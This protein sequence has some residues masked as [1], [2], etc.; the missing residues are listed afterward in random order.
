M[1]WRYKRIWF[2]LWA[3]ALLLTAMTSD[4]AAQAGPST[5][6][7][8]STQSV[9]REE[10]LP[11]LQEL[12]AY[13]A[14]LLIT[15]VDGSELP[16]IYYPGSRTAQWAL[17]HEQ[18]KVRYMQTWARS[19]GVKLVEAEPFLKISWFRPRG[20]TVQL[21]IVQTLR[22]GYSYPDEEAQGIV[23]EFGIGTRHW[24]ELAKKDGVWLIRREWYTDPLGDDTLIY[25][26]TPAVGLAVPEGV[27]PTTPPPP[28][29]GDK[30][31]YDRLKAAAYADK[32]AGS[33]WGA[34][35]DGKYN[36][37]YRD[38]NGI[39]GDCTNFVSQV[40]GDKKE[41]GGLPR[42]G[43]WAYYGSGGSVAWVQTDSFAHWLRYSGRARLVARGRFA[44]VTT[45]NDNFP[46]GAIRALKLGDVVA[47][48]E[49]NDVQHFSV[50]TAF[51]SKGYPMVNAHTADRYHSPW[52]LGW[53][54]SAYFWLFHLV[55]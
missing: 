39:G 10:F 8:P 14:S 13:R 6:Q 23:N 44:D 35:N 47:F 11:R 49:K 30:P 53:D 17:E 2:A 16:R 31:R 20:D 4:P 15:G 46:Q 26:P 40:L 41:G 9:T 29:Q 19:R 3:T 18:N 25:R 50:I 54:R 51:D 12:Y 48:E 7:T 34:G 45:P 24:L 1:T 5:T 37:R 28:E 36:P 52:D 42:D 55:D 22:L 33:A 21:G 43:A 27:D 32:Y 38:Y